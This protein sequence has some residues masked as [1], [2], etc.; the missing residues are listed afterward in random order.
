MLRVCAERVA[1]K[2][3]GEIDGAARDPFALTLGHEGADHHGRDVVQ[4]RFAEG[5]TLRPADGLS[6]WQWCRPFGIGELCLAGEILLEMV[7]E[8]RGAADHRELLSFAP[9]LE[10]A[11]FGLGSGEGVGFSEPSPAGFTGAGLRL[12]KV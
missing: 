7:T 1:Q 10:A 12:G 4:A 5:G 3:N 8:F 9:G 2:H 11:Q 6:P